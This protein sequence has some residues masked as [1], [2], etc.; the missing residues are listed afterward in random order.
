M[1]TVWR[2]ISSNPTPASDITSSIM[3]KRISAWPLPGSQYEAASTRAFAPVSTTAA[4][5]AESDVSNDRVII[6]LRL[7]GALP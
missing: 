6:K 7:P 2:S 5:Q 1:V 4:E 3:P